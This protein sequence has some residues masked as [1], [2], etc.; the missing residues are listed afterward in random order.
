[1]KK[2]YKDLHSILMSHIMLKTFNFK[3][4]IMYNCRTRFRRTRL[5][6][7]DIFPAH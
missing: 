6:K 3:R 4:K 1:M 2:I 7:L 5:K